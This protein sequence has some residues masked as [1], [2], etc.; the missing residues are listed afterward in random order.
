MDSCPSRAYCAG[1][2]TRSLTDD[3][4]VDPDDLAAFLA[5]RLDPD[6]MRALEAHVA[7]CPDCRH[8]LSE[9]AAGG[10]VPMVSAIGL[11]PTV[12]SLARDEDAELAPGTKIGRY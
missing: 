10:A 4:C 1:A 12:P 11:A 8:L 3:A 2:M 7:H 5:G 6:P 9:L